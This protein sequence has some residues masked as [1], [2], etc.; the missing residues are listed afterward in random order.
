MLYSV[1][2][3]YKFSGASQRRRKTITTLVV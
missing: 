3:I 2:V 1:V